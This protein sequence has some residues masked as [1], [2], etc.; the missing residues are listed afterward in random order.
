MFEK[1][2][3]LRE[4]HHRVKNNLAAIIGLLELQRRAMNDSLSGN[5]LAELSN[6][7][8]AMSLVH[9]KLYRSASLSHID[10]QD[11]IQSLISHLR[12]SFGSPS[13]RCEIAVRECKCLWIWRYLVE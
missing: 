8:R 9:E 12:T 10:F 3:L 6:R 4:V 5:V 2:V 1:K 13:I 7:V 11:Y